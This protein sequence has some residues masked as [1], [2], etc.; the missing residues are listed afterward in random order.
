[1]DCPGFFFVAG[2]D[3]PDPLA[4]AEPTQAS[5]LGDWLNKP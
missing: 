1:V 5:A 2:Q 3:A 4:R